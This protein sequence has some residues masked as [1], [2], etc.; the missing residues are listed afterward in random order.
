[1]GA[2][3]FFAERGASVLVTDLRKEKELNIRSLSDLKN[4]EFRLGEHKEDDFKRAQIVVVNPAV[5]EDSKM[6]KI[7]R[8]SGAVLTTEINLFFERCRSEIIGITGTNG[9]STTAALCHHILNGFDIPAHLG[10]NI[11]ESLLPNVEKFSQEEVVV[12]ELSSF[13]LERLRWTK[14]SPS[15]GAVLN[16]TPNHLDRHKTME[17]YGEAKAAILDYQKRNDFAVLNPD[18]KYF[19][20][21]AKRVKGN[22]AIFEK[23]FGKERT[24]AALKVGFSDGEIIVEIR[25]E[26]GE[27][28]SFSVELDFLPTDEWGKSW[29]A[30]AKGEVGHNALNLAAALGCAVSLLIRRK[31]KIE[32]EE[33]KRALER[34]TKEFRPL[35]H[36]LEKVAVVNGV[37]FINDSIA[38]NPE[39]VMAAL[40]CYPARRVV[41]IAGGYDKGLSYQELAKDILKRV[42][43]IVLIVS[44]GGLKIG[45]AMLKA[46][47]EIEGAISDIESEEIPSFQFA[48]TLEEA[49][50]KAFKSASTGDVVLLSPACASYGMFANFEERG[51]AF[52]DF[53]LKLKLREEGGSCRIAQF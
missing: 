50:K 17:A 18:D 9:K 3:R 46:V 45:E 41:L 5:S 29:R 31:Q 37:E 44:D 42:K 14:R 15:V 32:R 39:S 2:V 43:S 47:K 20:L 26:R 10:G 35:K 38:T 8:E 36:R 7:A 19:H 16:L 13:Q 34:A 27:K 25:R 48:L 12:L 21:F 30:E 24:D 53:V 49:V 1:E 11:G 6:L 4:V 22:L 52:K 33:M 40:S 23:D 28:E 51:E